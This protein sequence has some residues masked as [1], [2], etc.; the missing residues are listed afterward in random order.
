MDG[1]LP[2]LSRHFAE[3]KG[4]AYPPM[5]R[6]DRSYIDNLHIPGEMTEDYDAVF[7]RAKEAVTETWRQLGEALGSKKPD[8]FAMGN[9]DLDTG[10]DQSGRMMF[11]EK[12][13]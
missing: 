5:A 11:W 6:L 4:I 3:E 10:L 7:D 8:Q 9:G 13:A 2:P 12:T 1:L